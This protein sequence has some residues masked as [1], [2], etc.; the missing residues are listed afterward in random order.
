MNTLSYIYSHFWSNHRSIVIYVLMTCK[1]QLECWKYSLVV[2]VTLCANCC[3]TYNFVTTYLLNIKDPLLINISVI[4]IGKVFC[5]ELQQT[6]KSLKRSVVPQPYPG[7]TNRTFPNCNNNSNTTVTK[8][9][10]LFRRIIPLSTPTLRHRS[11]IS[12]L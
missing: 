9:V 3:N 6:V 11:M 1:H 7:L 10:Q 12:C 4:W 8:L 5:E 2:T